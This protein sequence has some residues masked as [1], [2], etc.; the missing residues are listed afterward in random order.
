MTGYRFI[1][2]PNAPQIEGLKFRY[3][4][5][6][7]DFVALLGVIEASQIHDKVDPLS[8]DA[9]IPTVDELRESFATAE[10][11]TLET[12]M[13]IVM[14]HDEVIG[15]QWVRWWDLAEGTWIYYHRGRVV[16]QWRAQGIGTAT[17]RWVE[18][19]AYELASE[20]GTLG[21][22]VLRANTT[23]HEAHY[24]ELLAEKGYMPVHSF[25]ELG[26]VDSLG[27]LPER[28]APE[29][30]H[31]RPVT[32]EDYRAIWEANEE[33]FAEE[34]GHREPDK[35]AYIRFLTKIMTVE[36]FDPALWQVAW[37]GEEVAGV[38]LCEITTRGVAEISDLS[39]RPAHRQQGLGL[40]LLVNSVHT[41]KEAGYPHIRLFTDTDDVF[42]ARS[43]YE[44]I[45]FR[46]LTQYIRYQKP[47]TEPN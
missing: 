3:F 22:A 4:H 39:V 17:L 14:L 2:L 11:I 21:K 28:F 43:L 33:A 6:D 19:R 40:S 8:P 9:G 32:K 15:F 31:F 37:H 34:W 27:L 5:D 18:Q 42:G 41:L 7:S 25:I 30:Y 47:L 16:P 38:A 20:H 1:E 13:L 44:S 29:G 23:Q 35:N 46:L 10:N 45:G 12:D 36:G 24:N 26:Y